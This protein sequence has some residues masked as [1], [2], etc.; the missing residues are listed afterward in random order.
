VIG[1]VIIRRRPDIII[2]SWC[3]K[4]VSLDAICRRPGWNVIP[5]IRNG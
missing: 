1:E 5:A 2:A 4:K 3:G